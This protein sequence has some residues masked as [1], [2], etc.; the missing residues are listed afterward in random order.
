M[1]LLLAGGVLVRPRGDCSF[2]GGSVECGGIVWIDRAIV[3]ECSK[4]NRYFV[5][6]SIA[7]VDLIRFF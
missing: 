6:V 2:A 3:G 1:L 7:N 5:G 4:I